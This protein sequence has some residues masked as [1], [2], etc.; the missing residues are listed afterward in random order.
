MNR[1]QRPHSSAVKL[2]NYMF[3]W[4][5]ISFLFAVFITVVLPRILGYPIQ[6]KLA[7]PDFINEHLALVKLI[8]M[9]NTLVMFLVPALVFTLV[10]KHR[11]LKFFKLNHIPPFTLILLALAIVVCSFPLISASNELN[12]KIPLPE[13]LTSQEQSIDGMIETYLQMSGP[14]DLFINLIL[15]AFLPA[16]AEEVFFRG[17]LQKLLRQALGNPDIAILVTAAFF[18]GMHMQFSGFLPRFILGVL[19]GYIYYWGRNLW[20]PIICHFIFNGSQVILAYV[21]LQYPD[22]FSGSESDPGHIGMGVTLISLALL[23]LLLKQ[24]YTRAVVRR[25]IWL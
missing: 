10:Q 9:G 18:S 15:L 22:K 17:G 16:L 11:P 1:I 6:D 23:F 14:A 12:Q 24:F 2:I 4:L 13:F 7:D 8:N 25:E 21:M 20:L 3:I 19:F 5:G